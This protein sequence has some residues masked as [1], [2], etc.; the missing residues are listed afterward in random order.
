M[1]EKVIKKVEKKWQEMP[2]DE[3]ERVIRGIL[4]GLN[5]AAGAFWGSLDVLTTGLPLLTAGVP[6]YEAFRAAEGREQL[7]VKEENITFL[8]H[9]RVKAKLYYLGGAVLP[10]AIAY[11][12]ELA[13][14][15]S[16][17]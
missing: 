15:I 9:N 17:F 1:L 10:F 7:G 2:E 12:N 4:Y 8:R 11:R 6:L 13:D 14:L 3:R 5:S 16:G